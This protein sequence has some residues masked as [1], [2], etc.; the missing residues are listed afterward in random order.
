MKTTET[1]SPS[2]PRVAGPDW[3]ACDEEQ[4]A[5]TSGC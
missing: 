1:E 3:A 5:T 4:E 2:I